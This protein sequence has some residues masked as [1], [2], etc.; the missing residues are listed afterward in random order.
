MEYLYLSP[1]D[2]ENAE[3]FFILP[4]LPDERAFADACH[5]LDLSVGMALQQFQGMI[6]L[7]FAVLLWSVLLEVGI[8]SRYG[9]SLAGALNNHVTLK[10]SKRKQ[11][12]SHQC[13]HG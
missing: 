10:L 3:L 5:F 9:F 7:C 6:D 12:V 1:S 4:A 13:A 2:G 11:N 8:L